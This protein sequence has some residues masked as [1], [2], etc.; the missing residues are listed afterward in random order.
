V[1]VYLL[2]EGPVGK[3]VCDDAFVLGVFL[4]RSTANRELDDHVEKAIKDLR[5]AGVPYKSHPIIETN[6][7]LGRDGQIRLADITVSG[8]EPHIA[9]WVEPWD[10]V[11]SPLEALAEQAE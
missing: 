10:A 3:R 7:G 6:P 5:D 2:R 9:F 8:D 11:G 1:K 4:S